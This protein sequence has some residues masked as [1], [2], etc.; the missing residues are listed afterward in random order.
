MVDTVDINTTFSVEMGVA[1]NHQAF[2]DLIGAIHLAK[3][4][5]WNKSTQQ[6][7]KAVGLLNIAVGEMINLRAVIGNNIKR[8]E[9]VNKQY[10]QKISSNTAQV[11]GETMQDPA[12]AS[13]EMQNQYTQFLATFRT[14]ALLEKLKLDLP[15]MI[16]G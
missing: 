10:N 11:V 2:Q 3:Q 12:E 6:F 16:M 5:N 7:S 9:D 13:V 14:R 8:V 4:A 1:A 15:N